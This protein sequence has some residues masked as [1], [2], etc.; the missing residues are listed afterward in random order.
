MNAYRTEAPSL[1]I[2]FGVAAVALT[3]LTMSLAIV[4]PANLEP[5]ASE[6]LALATPSAHV[7]EVSISPAVVD[8]VLYREHRSAPE[9]T[10]SA[11][12]T[13][14]PARAARAVPAQTRV[15]PAAASTMVEWRCPSTV[16]GHDV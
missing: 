13:R 9:T 5:A 14:Q 7:T 1:R 6:A 4:V 3:A 8:V 16:D 15:A 12:T 10:R 2:A 11:L